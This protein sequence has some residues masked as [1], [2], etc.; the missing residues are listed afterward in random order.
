MQQIEPNEKPTTGPPNIE[1][2]RER[3]IER[4]VESGDKAGLWMAFVGDQMIAM[5]W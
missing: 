1:R 2:E 4:E 5:M 3:E